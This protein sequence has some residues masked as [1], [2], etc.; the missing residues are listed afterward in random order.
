MTTDPLSQ[1]FSRAL[2]RTLRPPAP[3]PEGIIQVA[4]L[5]CGKGDLSLVAQEA[6]MA[7]VYAEEPDTELRA[8]YE[9]NIGLAPQNVSRAIPF[10][11]IPAFDLLLITL[12][13]DREEREKALA[14]AY[15]FLY[16]RKLRAFLFVGDGRDF[17]DA[18]TLTRDKAGQMGYEVVAGE[19]P[20]TD[21]GQY[22]VLGVLGK[23]DVD[24]DPFGGLLLEE[25][26][27]LPQS[28][29]GLLLDFVAMYVRGEID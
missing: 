14:Y 5:F 13:E 24:L 28:G 21:N 4:D 20:L 29:V 10:G 18:E 16:I 25:E 2:S 12:P 3:P 23:V 7:V 27:D 15:R 1:D 9:S 6:G 26:P 8:E 22:F 17:Q 11:D 19:I